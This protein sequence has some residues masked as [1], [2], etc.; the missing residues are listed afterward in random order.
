[1]IH[2]KIDLLLHIKLRLLHFHKIFLHFPHFRGMDVE[3][4]MKMKVLKAKLFQLPNFF[5]NH[6]PIYFWVVNSDC[7]VFPVL[8]GG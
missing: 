8:V 3:R 5:K 2:N 6:C 1:M 7:V 4:I